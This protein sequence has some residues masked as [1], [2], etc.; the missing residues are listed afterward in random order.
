MAGRSFA[1]DQINVMVDLTC[2]WQTGRQVVWED[3]G[4]FLKQLEECWVMRR[5]CRWF[6][7]GGRGKGWGVVR[8]GGGGLD[9]DNLDFVDFVGLVG[10]AQGSE[11]HEAQGGWALGPGRGRG[12]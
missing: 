1:W 9:A 8:A 10:V 12:S 3:I 11:G 7:D 6:I 4:E 2:R 5:R